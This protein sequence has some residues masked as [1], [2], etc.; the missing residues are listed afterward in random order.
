MARIDA[1]LTQMAQTEASDLHLAVGEP[2]K[3]RIHG[4][5]GPISKEPLTKATLEPLLLEILTEEQ[6]ARF[7]RNHDLDFAYEVKGVARFRVN[8]FMQ[9]NGIGAAFRLIPS[10]VWTLEE[11]GAPPVVEKFC[12]LRSGL[13]LVTGPTGSGKSTTLAAMTDYINERYDKHI[14][15]VEDPI[16]FV[17]ENKRCLIT[18]REVFTDTESFAA[19]LRSSM[20]QDP[21]V[22]LV[23]EMRD[24]ETISLA[25]TL[26]EM[27]ILVFA[28]LHTNSAVKTVDRIIDV[29][30]PEQQ[31]QTRTM[32]SHSL[33]GVVAQTLL[34]KA[35]G[36]GRFAAH[37]ILVGSD[38]LGNIIREGRIEK[39]KS[40]IEAGRSQGMETMDSCIMRHLKAG[41]ITG[42]EAYEKAHDKKLFE[43]YWDLSESVVRT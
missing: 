33:K 34:R 25:V 38:A 15:T 37:E 30:P 29:F 39:I 19:A 8:Y 42:R 18:Q 16:E 12:Q 9:Q 20:R 14:L 32:L 1:L 11:C 21:D 35:D 43:E 40:L 6:R 41:R 36:T 26:A 24:L 23:G 17:H 5:L 7:E 22:V 3:F 2:P 4:D 31:P 27:G 28:T 10:V 13:V